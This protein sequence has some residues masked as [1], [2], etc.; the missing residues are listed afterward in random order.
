VIMHAIRHVTLNISSK[1]CLLFLL[2]LLLAIPSVSSAFDGKRKGFLAGVGLGAAP[3]A[4]WSSESEDLDVDEVGFSANALLGYGWDSRN[5]IVYEGNGGIYRASALRDSW[6]TQGLDAIK[7]YHY[8]GAG[9]RE[10]FSCVG[11]GLWAFGTQYRNIDGDGFGYTAGVG[12]E[13]LKHFQVG[14]Y[15]LGG[16]TSNEDDVEATHSVVTLLVTV[17]GY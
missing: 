5:A 1:K 7:W 15:Y 6:V 13:F 8:W 2:V 9:D 17:I 16:D 3:I 12:Y 14:L 11:I 10:F 4:H